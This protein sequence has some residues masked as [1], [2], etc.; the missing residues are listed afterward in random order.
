MSIFLV[1]S[2][3]FVALQILLEIDWDIWGHSKASG[4]LW[5]GA[6][7]S[8]EVWWGEQRLHLCST[9]CFGINYINIYIIY[10]YANFIRESFVLQNS[11][12]LHNTWETQ[13]LKGYSNPHKLANWNLWQGHQDTSFTLQK[14]V[15]ICNV[16]TDCHFISSFIKHPLFKEQS[17]ERKIRGNEPTEFQRY[18]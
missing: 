17:H 18:C 14:D 16:N 15:T 6:Y 11:R 12:V 9:Q 10:K 4:S 7:G 1:D 5:W 2:L 13:L 3:S 8:H